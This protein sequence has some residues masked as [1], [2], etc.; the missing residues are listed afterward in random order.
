MP[1]LNIRLDRRQVKLPFEKQRHVVVS[2]V[3]IL[4]LAIVIGRKVRRVVPRT[5]ELAAVNGAVLEDAR[6]QGRR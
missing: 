6:R 3:N 5:V 4:T 2:N 1:H